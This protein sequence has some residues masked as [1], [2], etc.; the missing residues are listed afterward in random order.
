MRAYQV[1]RV[2]P[3][4]AGG[5]P[6]SRAADDALT[7]TAPVRIA[8]LPPGPVPVAEPRRIG[9]DPAQEEVATL[10]PATATYAVGRMTRMTRSAASWIGYCREYRRCS[11][12]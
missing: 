8:R 9:R 5:R 2:K 10:P 1:Q 3:Q 6:S 11:D 7:R 12:W 4:P